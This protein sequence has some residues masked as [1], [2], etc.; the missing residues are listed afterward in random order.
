MT[1]KYYEDTVLE[2]MNRVPIEFLPL[3]RGIV[4][5]ARAASMTREKT[6]Y[7]LRYIVAK[8]E[9][10]FPFYNDRLIA[11]HMQTLAR[12]SKPSLPSGSTVRKISGKPFKSGSKT[13][14]VKEVVTRL[15][16]PSMDTLL[17]KVSHTRQAYSFSTEEEGYVVNVD[18][19][20]LVS[21]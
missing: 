5:K 11:S 17:P 8:I 7:L 16:P 2:Q 1:R 15:I 9:L 21:E 3:V 13:A 20:E 19:C 10:V 18:M 4:E 12:S 6:L 14:V